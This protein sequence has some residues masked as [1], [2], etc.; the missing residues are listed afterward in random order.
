[1]SR[2]R[3]G[4]EPTGAPSIVTCADG[5]D[6]TVRLPVCAGTT[7]WPN[8]RFAFDATA[9]GGERLLRDALVDL[10][11][12]REIAHVEQLE[13]HDDGPAAFGLLQRSVDEAIGAERSTGLGE[14]R[15]R[16]AVAVED[17][18]QLD[19]IFAG[20]EVDALRL[21]GTSQSFGELSAER[22]ADLHRVD[23]EDRERLV[24]G[25]GDPGSDGGEHE[26]YDRPDEETRKRAGRRLATHRCVLYINCA[27]RLSISAK[28]FSGFVAVLAI[29]SAVTGYTVFAMRRLGDELRLVSSGYL[30]LRLTVAELQNSHSN[31]LVLFEQVRHGD[32]QKLPRY[33][34]AAMDD[35]RR[36]RQRQQLAL[37]YDQLRSLSERR[38]PAEERPLL[39]ALRGRLDRIGAAFRES[40]GLFDEVFGALGDSAPIGPETERQQDATDRL[41][42]RERTTKRELA[43]LAMELRLRAQQTALRLEDEE[44]HA[45]WAAMGLAV[46]ALVVG[47][48]VA[49]LAGRTLTPLRRLAERTKE[50]ARGDYE[51]RVPADGGDEIAA[52]A[53]AFNAMAEALNEREQ[54]LIRHERLAAIG[55]IAAQITHEVRNPLSSIGLNAEQLEEELAALPPDT[56]AE[57]RTIARAI[58]KEVDRLAE[59]TEAYLRFARMPQPRLEREELRAVIGSLVDFQRAELQRRQITIEVSLPESECPLLCDE[60]QMRQALLNLVRNAGEAMPS[61][62]T[63]RITLTVEDDR[64]GYRLEIADSGAGID[65][66]NLPHV[67][68]PFFSTKQGGTGLGLALTQQIVVEHGGRIEVQSAPGRGTTFT[69]HVPSA[70]D[71]RT[72]ARAA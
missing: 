29:F 16:F 65:P 21:G 32:A 5:V 37:A 38:L 53:R 33:L 43:S 39:D 69:V 66:S 56:A 51:K 14:A 22:V 57:A 58:V 71:G 49:V 61:G 64:R 60:Q 1:M 9:A 4:V 11:Y 42:K 41:L 50:I 36:I 7:S 68:E 27:M 62:G 52:L 26:S 20:H 19:E 55:K 15:R 67:F 3:Y 31:L 59:I 12:D 47:F 18:L 23:A 13:D 25:A 35:A 2:A 54:Q 34:K 8:H 48:V 24:G 40:E 45:I 28:I 10:L 70:N 46:F 44:S 63:L 72:D 17:H 30:E 6:T